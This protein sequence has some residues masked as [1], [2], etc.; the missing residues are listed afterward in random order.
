METFE[1]ERRQRKG[2]PNEKSSSHWIIHSLGTKA[3]ETGKGGGVEAGELT[4]PNLPLPP[5]QLRIRL[6]TYME[7]EG[8]GRRR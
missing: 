5:L 4:H 3:V 1:K 8:E 7:D 2:G 6:A